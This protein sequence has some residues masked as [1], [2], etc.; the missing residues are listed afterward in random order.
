MT[1]RTF[2]RARRERQHLHAARP[3]RRAHRAR[4]LCALDGPRRRAWLERRTAVPSARR[5]R[6]KRC[7]RRS[8]QIVRKRGRTALTWEIGT[9]ATPGDLANACSRSGL[10]DDEPTPLAVGM[11]LT[12]PPPAP[13]PAVEVRRAETPEE[14][15]GVG[16]DRGDRLRWRRCRPSCRRL[17]DDPNNVVYL[18]LV[19]GAPVA[20]AR[21]PRSASAPSRSSAAPRCRRRAVGARTGHSLRRAGKTR[22]PAARPPSSRRRARCRGRSSHGSGSARSARSGSCSTSSLR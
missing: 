1:R 14:R 16:E 10:V 18:A 8:T 12:E 19:D 21:R 4:P 7:G 2:A 17:N 9:H 15:A 5:R 20:R 11:V 3:D 6:W 13:P 22:W